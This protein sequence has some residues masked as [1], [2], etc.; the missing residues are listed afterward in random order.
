MNITHSQT[1][2]GS[3]PRPL[4]PKYSS[5]NQPVTQNSNLSRNNSLQ[6]YCKKFV[7]M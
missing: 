3:L 7:A 1:S 2:V 4:L 5:P 6:I